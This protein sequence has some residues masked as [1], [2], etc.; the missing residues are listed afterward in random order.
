MVAPAAFTPG[1]D[2][3]W[4]TMSLKNCAATGRGAGTVAFMTSTFSGRKPRYTLFKATKL[5]ISRPDAET[6]N[7][8]K[9]ISATTRALRTRAMLPP[10]TDRAPCFSASFTPTLDA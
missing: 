4:G 10:A 9:A 3:I 7:T 1:R 6:S 2:A 8:A 5:R